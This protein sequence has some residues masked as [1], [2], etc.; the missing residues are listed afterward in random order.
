MA[1]FCSADKG[2]TGIN[3]RARQH[4]GGSQIAYAI[5]MRGKCDDEETDRALPSVWLGNA[6]LMGKRLILQAQQRAAS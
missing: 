6:M 1:L 3:R 5:A 2:S 4:L